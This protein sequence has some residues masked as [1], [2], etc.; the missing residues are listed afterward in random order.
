[1]SD[2]FGDR[3]AVFV[4]ET[5]NQPMSTGRFFLQDFLEGIGN[6]E[7]PINDYFMAM[8]YALADRLNLFLSRLL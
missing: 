1:M 3:E 8:P 6:A 4:I 7:L 2:K 5:T